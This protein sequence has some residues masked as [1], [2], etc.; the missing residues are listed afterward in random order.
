M[1]C[2]NLFICLL[3][4]FFFFFFFFFTFVLFSAI[5][6]VIHGKVL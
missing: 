1:M 2:V 3:G 5:E 6:H 4:F